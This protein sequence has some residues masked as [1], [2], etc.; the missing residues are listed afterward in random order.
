MYENR[1]TIE[2][3][4]RTIAIPRKSRVSI[5]SSHDDVVDVV[6]FQNSQRE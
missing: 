6:V 1:D 4:K 5:L 2:I 3:T